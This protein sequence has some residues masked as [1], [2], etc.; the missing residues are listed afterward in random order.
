MIPIRELLEQQYG[1]LFEDE[2]LTEIEASSVYKNIPQGQFI[3]NSYHTRIMGL[4]ETVEK[5]GKIEMFRS[6]IKILEL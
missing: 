6:Y 4:A 1:Y 5:E 3:L 2:I